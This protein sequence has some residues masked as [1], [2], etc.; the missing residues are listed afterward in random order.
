MAEGFQ[1]TYPVIMTAGDRG[2][3]R[4]I[5]GTNKAL[6]ELAGAPV[7]THVL[8]AL[9]Q[10]PSVGRIYLVGPRSNL[11]AALDRPGI[12]FKGRKPIRL[13]E[14]WENLYLNVWNTFLTILREREGEGEATDSPVLVVPS[15]IPLVIPEEIEEFIRA[16]DMDRF[17]YEVGITSEH[18]LSLY[19]PQKRRKGIRLMYFHMKEGSFRQN[20]LHLVKPLRMVNRIYVQK[21]YDY[22][23]QREWG[24]ILRLFW[25]IYRTEEGTLR[26]LGQ[27]VLL[28]LASILYR[29]PWLS[30]HRIPAAFVQK[31]NL[32]ICI[33]NLLGTRFTTVETHYGGA[34]LD[35]DTAEHYAVIQE[36]F[37]PWKQMQRGE[38]A[39]APAEGL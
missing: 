34:A 22:R 5:Y 26:M 18:F 16:C 33:S 31:R 35:I 21:T 37:E 32:E 38:F 28:H 12:P 3:A 19:Y 2:R 1:G 15:D 24:N 29:V 7:F 4:L 6:L 30:L 14:Q 8:A 39:S 17:D 10:C 23:L 9:E 11:S 20:N 25:E 13:L 36:N 27:Y